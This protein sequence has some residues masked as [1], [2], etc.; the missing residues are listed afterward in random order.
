MLD[1]SGANNH[2]EI[3]Q[4]GGVSAGLAFDAPGN[5]YY[6]TS[7]PTVDE[8]LVRYSASQ[9]EGAKTGPPL[10]RGEAELL[11]NLPSGV[12][13]PQG[14]VVSDVV[15]DAVGNVLFNVNQ[16]D[17]SDYDSDL[18]AVVLWNGQPGPGENFTTLTTGVVPG[19]QW[20]TMLAAQGDVTD[21]GKFYQGDYYAVGVAEV[22]H[23]P[24]PSAALMLLATA[25]VGLLW[26]KRRR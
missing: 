24:E 17:T 20:H 3:A 22:S 4:V 21:G 8:A 2:R 9:V 15:V 14:A 19:G 16:V 25:A 10:S 13:Y 12:N 5:L 6:G 26:W 11:S 18:S 23:V 1:T 7:N